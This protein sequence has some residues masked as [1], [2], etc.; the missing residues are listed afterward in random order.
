MT[1]QGMYDIHCDKVQD[2]NMVIVI[3][4]NNDVLLLVI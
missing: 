2:N 3:V 4:G 1:T